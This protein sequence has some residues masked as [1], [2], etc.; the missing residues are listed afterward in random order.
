MPLYT[1]FQSIIFKSSV[2]GDYIRIDMTS[3][4][5]FWSCGCTRYTSIKVVFGHVAVHVTPLSKLF[6]VMWLYTL[7]LCQSCFWSCGCTHYT[8]VKVV[9][10]HVAVHVTPLSKLFF[11]MWLYMLHLCQSCFWSCGCTRYTSVKVV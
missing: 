5:G 3:F 10:G 11:V 1:T 2:S 4:H 7:H 6:L 9:F 8:S